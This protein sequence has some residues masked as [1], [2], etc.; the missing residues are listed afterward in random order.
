MDSQV[1]AD[2][3]YVGPAWVGAGRRLSNRTSVIGPAILWDDP[4]DRPKVQTVKWGELEPTQ[5]FIQPIRPRTQSAFYFR[6]KRCFDIV[7]ATVILILL[8]P[9]FPLIWLAIYLEDGRPLFFAHQRETLGGRLFPCLKFRSMYRNADQIKERLGD[10]NEAD[11]PQ[12]Y[13]E[14]DPRLTRVGR[15][16]RR[17]HL[18]ELPQLFNVLAGHMSMVGPR[19]SPHEENQ[20]CPPWR[21]ARLSVRPGITGLWQVM[22]TRRKGLDFQEWIKYDIEYV[23]KVSLSLDLWILFKTLHRLLTGR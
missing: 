2:T 15:L 9:I 19:P 4:A 14:D 16:L 7:L 23:E 18:D 11:G 13:M 8:L 12:F 6:A 22:R 5:V 17:L 20:Y 10:R 21:E 3:E 1:A